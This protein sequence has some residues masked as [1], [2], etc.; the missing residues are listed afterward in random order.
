MSG[1]RPKN[2]CVHCVRGFGERPVSEL[3]TFRGWC[4]DAFCRDLLLQLIILYCWVAYTWETHDSVCAPL[5]G[6][7]HVTPFAT[8]ASSHPRTTLQRARHRTILGPCKKPRSMSLLPV[9]VPQVPCF[10]RAARN[11]VSGGL[12]P[13]NPARRLPAAMVLSQSL[14]GR[15]R[16][17][18]FNARPALALLASVAVLCAAL[19]LVGT[20]APACASRDLAD[21][22]RNYA[23]AHGFDLGSTTEHPEG[24]STAGEEVTIGAIG[25]SLLAKK[26]PPPLRSSPPPKPP[27]SPKR[28]PPPRPPPPSP[29]SPRP[30]PPPLAADSTDGRLGRMC[31][32]QL[33][34]NVLACRFQ[35][36]M[37]MPNAPTQ[38]KFAV[39]T[40]RVYVLPWLTCRRPWPR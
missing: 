35:C 38:L 26:S 5:L 29:P 7:A 21:V 13:R 24:A 25:R 6:S 11:L 16:T 12:W 20:P 34:S 33:M 1:M 37:G 8:F 36:G 39:C 2:A 30:P 17:T 31:S 40:S 18:P 28:S 14:C 4:G 15:C 19:L 23:V 9:L 22:V 3:A 10:Q 27:P 32:L